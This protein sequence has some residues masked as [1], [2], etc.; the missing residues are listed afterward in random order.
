V[1]VAVVDVGANTLRLLVAKTSQGGRL[2]TVTE[3]RMQLGLGEEIE[4]RGRISRRKLRAVTKTARFQLGRARKLDCTRV[5]VLITSPGRQSANADDL[6]AALRAAGA[7]SVRVLSAEEEA[8]LAWVGA[9]SAASDLPEAIAVCDVGGG[10]T[11]IAVGTRTAGPSWA[12]SYDV[13]SLRLSSRLLSAD[14]PA[15]SAVAA[16]RVE[17]ARQ[18]SLVVGTLPTTGLATGGTARTLRRIV[19]PTL[20]HQALETAVLTLAGR[21]RRSISKSYGIDRHRARTLL[22]GTILLSEAQRSLGVPLEVARGGIREGAA[23]TLLDG[24]QALSA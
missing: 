1:R 18:L 10:S 21:T 11:Q 9:I 24:A 8:Q 19:G 23:V 6:L 4:A 20:D 7:A 2:A 15:P 22:A 16:A 14:P 12:Q 17:A 13:G 3:E 5:Q